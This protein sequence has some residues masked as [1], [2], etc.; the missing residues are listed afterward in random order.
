MAQLPD[1][2]KPAAVSGID[3]FLQPQSMVTPGVL[4][5]VA[6]FGTNALCEAF[7]G[8]AP[9]QVALGL[10]FFFGIVTIVKTSTLAEKAVYYVVNSLIILS[11][12]FGTNSIGRTTARQVSSLDLPVSVASFHLISPAY[13]QTRDGSKVQEFFRP[14]GATPAPPPPAPAPAPAMVPYRLAA[15][16]GLCTTIYLPAGDTKAVDSLRAKLEPK[17]IQVLAGACPAN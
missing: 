12:A 15:P 11:M 4:G 5:T 1:A 17:G 14:W 3:Q 13:A 7:P 16:E 10:S 2:A 9:V 8:A 6:M